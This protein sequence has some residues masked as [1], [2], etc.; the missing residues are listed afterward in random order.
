M[1]VSINKVY[2]LGN[3]HVPKSNEASKTKKSEEQKKLDEIEKKCKEPS[4]DSVKE[5]LKKQQ[6]I[7]QK[8]PASYNGAIRDVY[9]WTQTIK[10]IDIQVNVK[11]FLFKI[12]L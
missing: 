10:D 2:L 4:N 7:F 12:K 5:K 3:D 11:Y 6:E 8:N 1:K 9:L